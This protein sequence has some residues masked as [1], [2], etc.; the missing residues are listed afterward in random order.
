MLT[1]A[2]VSHKTSSRQDLTPVTTDSSESPGF[3][4]GSS[5]QFPCSYL[6]SHIKPPSDSLGV[7]DIQYLRIKGALEVPNDDLMQTCLQSYAEHIHPVYPLLDIEE[8]RLIIIRKAG[9]SKISLL[10]LHAIIFSG[11]TWVDLRIIRRAGF[12]RRKE[13]RLSA[14]KRLRLLHDLDYEDDRLCVIQSLILMSFWWKSTDENKDAWHYLGIAISLARKIDL[15]RL[16][17]DQTFTP[18]MKRLRRRLWWTLLTREIMGCFGSNRTP[19]ISRDQSRVA[20]LRLD[21][22]EIFG[23]S[24]EEMAAAEHLAQLCIEHTK[25][26]QI[27]S[28]IFVEAGTEDRGG[29]TTVLYSSRQ[30]EGADEERGE[31]IDLQRLRNCEAELESWRDALPDSLWHHGSMSTNLT[32]WEKAE[33]AVKGLSAAIYFTARIVLHRPQ[34]LHKTSSD[35]G[36]ELPNQ[37]EVSRMH[38]RHASHAITS[39]FMDFF[40]AD[41]ILDLSATCISCLIPASINHAFDCFADDGTTRE[42]ASKSL[43]QCKAILHDFSE[44]QYAP[45]WILQTLDRI[46]HNL[47]QHRNLGNATKASSKSAVNSDMHL[48]REI[49]INTS[50]SLARSTSA[51]PSQPTAMQYG[52]DLQPATNSQCDAVLCEIDGLPLTPDMINLSPPTAVLGS[53]DVQSDFFSTSGRELSL[54]LYSDDLFLQPFLADLSYY[55]YSFRGL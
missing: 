15:H 8:T 53:H 4:T 43:E 5:A 49:P 51:R 6:A 26:G 30:I 23:A 11:C 44:Q 24:V 19:R 45:K 27:F 12:F 32:N 39:I 29:R 40:Q 34:M 46:M 50:H 18:S 7:E 28:K 47:A 3:A 33:A 38:V 21:D 14:Y 20:M 31:D 35:V 54:P 10:L 37:H 9:D 55:D 42:Q 16:D 25:L 36:S 52:D 2:S 1:R 41:M 48:Q 13:F 22:F 17:H